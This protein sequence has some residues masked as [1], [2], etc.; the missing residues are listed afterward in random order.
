[1]IHWDWFAVIAFGGI[2]GVLW[3][4]KALLEKLVT[5][6]GGLR[7]QLEQMGERQQRIEDRLY[8]IGVNTS[9]LPPARDSW[10]DD[11]IA[12]HPDRPE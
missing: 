2:F 9:G 4:I 11:L 7:W 1:M 5:S 8:Q 3:T 12:K 6:L 10:E